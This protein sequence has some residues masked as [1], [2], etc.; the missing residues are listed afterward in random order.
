MYR[1]LLAVG[2]LTTWASVCL[3]A[4][5]D[6]ARFALH[7]QAAI[8][9]KVNTVCTTSSP[10]SA[11]ISCESYVTSAPAPGYSLVYFVVG[12]APA[13]GVSGVSFGIDYNGRAGAQNG[14]DPTHNMFYMCADGLPF[15]NGVD[16]DQ[17]G[18]VGPDEDFPAPRGGTR[19]TWVTCANA[20]VGGSVHAIIGAL[21]CYAYSPDQLSITPNNNLTSGPELA[22]H[23]CDN[24][25]TQL[26][27]VFPAWVHWRLMARVDFGGGWGHNACSS[28]PYPVEPATWGALKT[29]Y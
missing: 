24:S 21:Q 2:V 20:T 15:H 10:S 18:V 4:A 25:V 7:R 9:T 27:E 28:D 13:V 23:T 8:T 14:I 26:L 11:G 6:D 22:V 16:L 12:H 17:D 19:I 29:K 3:G 5:A 1:M